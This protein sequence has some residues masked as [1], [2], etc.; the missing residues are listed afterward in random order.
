LFRES[1]GPANDQDGTPILV[2]TKNDDSAVAPP[3]VTT[4]TNQN[5]D[6]SG[7]SSQQRQEFPTL[8]VKS[9]L[10]LLGAAVSLLLFTCHCYLTQHLLTKT[11]RS[12][13][14]VPIM[15]ILPLSQDEQLLVGPHPIQTATNDDGNHGEDDDDE[16]DD[17]VVSSSNVTF[18][19][20]WTE[21]Q[22]H[23]VVWDKVAASSLFNGDASEDNTYPLGSMTLLVL[24]TVVYFMIKPSSP[25][26]SYTKDGPMPDPVCSNEASSGHA[27]CVPP[28]TEPTT[29]MVEYYGTGLDLSAYE[30][31]PANELRRLLRQRGCNASGTKDTLIRRLVTVTQAEL[32]TLTVRQLR[33]KLRA[34]GCNQSGTKVDIVRRLV[35]AGP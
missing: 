22:R 20:L 32:A 21:Q 10:L 15:T 5:E 11:V 14:D 28:K 13:N 34:R 1:L 23:Q 6:E 35:E 19:S 30:S 7:T 16:R 2:D 27:S 12:N 9:V 29:W 4:T 26:T 31:L 18:D 8:R 3:P 33:P 17:V 25:S 24:G